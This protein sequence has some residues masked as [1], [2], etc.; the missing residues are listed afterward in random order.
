[1]RFAGTQLSNFI[2]DTTDFTNIAGTA[3]NGRSQERR[4]VMS[5]EADKAIAS[6][7]SKATILSAEHQAD[8]IR[9]GGAAQGQASLW[10]GIGG[11]MS[12][13]GGGIGS[14]GSSSGGGYYGTGSTGGVGN[15]VRIGPYRE[16]W[17]LSRILEC[18]LPISGYTID[19]TTGL[20]NTG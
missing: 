14:M 16:V 19:P 9:A 7:N 5:G 10:Q 18:P 11:A 4:A 8:A 17:N 1:M 13:I 6:L 3:I 2:G 12:A 20:V 15:T